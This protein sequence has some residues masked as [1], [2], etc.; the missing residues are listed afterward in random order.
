MAITEAES[1]TSEVDEEIF[2][3]NLSTE[4]SN[5][6]ACDDAIVDSETTYVEAEIEIEEDAH[7]ES[8]DQFACEFDSQN[9]EV[10]DYFEQIRYDN[11]VQYSTL[12]ASVEDNNIEFN[13]ALEYDFARPEQDESELVRKV[14][15]NISRPFSKYVE[16]LTIDLGN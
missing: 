13:E 4:E 1:S 9:R 11:V 16:D 12:S 8:V 14:G 15:D 5:E 10:I 6:E 7:I 3:N 2:I